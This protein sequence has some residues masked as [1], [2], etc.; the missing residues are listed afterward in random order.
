M[1][2]EYLT[3]WSEDEE[4]PYHAAFDIMYYAPDDDTRREILRSA[5]RA[6]HRRE[7]STWHSLRLLLHLM[8]RHWHLLPDD[9]A[10]NAIRQV[11]DVIRIQPDGRLQGSFGGRRGTVTFS[12]QRAACLF[13]LLGP[14]RRL[15]P[16]LANAAI[17]DT[18]EL[19]RAAAIYPDGHETDRDRPVEPLSAEAL[20]QWKKDWTGFAL[21]MRFFRIED[22]RSS[23]FRDSFDHALRAFAR[24]AAHQRPN[25]FPRECWPS[26]EDFRTILYAAGKYDGRS[27]ARLLDRIPDPALRLFAQIEFAAAIAGLEQIG[28]ITLEQSR[29]FYQPHPTPT[30]P[31]E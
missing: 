9:E 2:I 8:Q 5:L 18:P 6:W 16:E 13:Q 10:R 15:D 4:F 21:G 22:E 11:V 7:D 28:G 24:D 27:G 17:R 23:D 1:A 19:S 20:E 29:G 12:S 30:L 14:L 26:A 25:P 3:Q 31:V